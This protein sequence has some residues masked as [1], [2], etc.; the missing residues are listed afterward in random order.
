MKKK[1]IY[2][3]FCSAVALA[4]C[5]GGGDD[6][7]AAATPQTGIS[8][9]KYVGT[10]VTDC[11]PSS[12]ASVA[13][14]TFELKGKV[15]L[16]FSK[17]SDTQASFVRVQDVYATADC[18]G[19]LLVSHTNNA[20]GNMLTI[21]GTA[22]VDGTAVDQLTIVVDNVGGLSAGD[23]ITLNGLVYP[24]DFFVAKK[25]VKEIAEVN[26]DVLKFGDVAAPTDERGYPTKLDSVDV[27]T[28]Q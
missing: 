12:I 21:D 3:A 26:G 13:A 1:A 18:S 22:T 10:W 8:I 11:T 4:G 16:T 14:P 24:G 9:Q 28:K 19:D 2:L 17:V 20:R 5:G 23:T 7:S 25:T 27:L 6:N 15:R